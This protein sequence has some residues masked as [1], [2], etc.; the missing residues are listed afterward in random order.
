[1]KRLRRNDRPAGRGGSALVKLATA[2]A[3]SSSRLEDQYWDSRLATVL[4][5]LLTTSGQHTIEAALERLWSV[6]GRAYDLL[7]DSAEAV[8]ESASFEQSGKHW[9]ALMFAVPLLAWARSRIPSGTLRPAELHALRA[10]LQAHIF[11]PGARL[12]LLNRLLTPDQLPASY[13]DE[14]LLARELFNAALGEQELNLPPEVVPEAMDF[15]TDARFVLGAV[16]VPHGQAIFSWAQEEVSFETVQQSWS[17]QVH[18]ALAPLM[19]GV[20]YEVL[21]PGAFFATL[22]KTDRESRA[23]HVQAGVA[24]LE[25]LLHRSAT[26]IGATFAPFHDRGELVEY[27]IGLGNVPT[28]EIWHGITWPVLSLDEVESA[29]GEIRELLQSLG[30]TQITEHEHRFPMEY[31]EEYGDPLFPNAAGET[32][33]AEPPEEADLAPVQLH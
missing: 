16:I 15:I 2:A 27:R 14:S 17:E 9:D 3:A 25:N 21:M 22:R 20:H 32:V 18:A 4:Q 30:V 28:N 13:Y 7:A 26:Q 5:G 1:M 10:Q 33:R 24:Y 31:S 6:N 12:S 8:I 19:A 23:F 29:P 11:M